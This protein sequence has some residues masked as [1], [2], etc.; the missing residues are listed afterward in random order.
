MYNSLR[1]Y[2]NFRTLDF[3]HGGGNQF[4]KALSKQFRCMNVYAENPKEAG[5]ILINSHQYFSEAL[6][7]KIRFP[8]KIFIHRIDGPMRIY[9]RPGDYRDAIVNLANK[10]IADAAVFQSKWSQ[11]SNHELGLLAKS[12][13]TVIHNASSPEIFNRTGR[14]A[15]SE[16]RKIRLIA[17]S[18]SPNLNKGFE[19]Y[20][21]LD[22]NLDF[23]KYQM[24]FIG[25]SPVKFKNIKHLPPVNS[26][27]L[28]ENFKQ[29]DIFIF[30]SQIEACSNLLLEALSCGLPAIAPDSSSNPE[31]VKTGGELFNQPSQIPNLIEK[32][33]ADYARYATSIKSPSIEETGRAY[34]DFILKVFEEIKQKPRKNFSRLNYLCLI[35]RV[36]FWKILGKVQCL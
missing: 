36:L 4:L 13:E 11:N 31:I 23:E 25:N 22:E 26:A 12:L 24:T 33:A 17:A 7:L 30:A 35:G 34:Y 32:I 16:N 5:C 27:A 29:N 8:D 14:I 18:W 19:T 10:Y 1:I 28:A 20:K 21:W 3:P 15:F 9:N 6:K 2:I